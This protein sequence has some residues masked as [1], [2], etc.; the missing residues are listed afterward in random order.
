MIAL[1]KLKSM[2]QPP[3]NRLCFL[4]KSKPPADPLKYQEPAAAATAFYPLHF[5]TIKD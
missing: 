5:K 4:C 3:G 1:Y 2:M